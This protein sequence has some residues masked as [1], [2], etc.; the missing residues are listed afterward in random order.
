VV[1]TGDD[2]G[3]EPAGRAC[4]RRST[5]GCWAHGWSTRWAGKSCALA[6]FAGQRVHAVAG[7]GNPQRFF[8]ALRTAGLHPIEHPFPD[9]HRYRPAE[10]QFGEPLP[11]IMTEKDAVKCL[12]FALARCWYLPV[13]A[14]F[15]PADEAP[16]WGEY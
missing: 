14:Q 7:I 6:S 12:S 16:C 2:P 13:S 15:A 4:N 10:L 8:A 1:W 11:V 9:H 3:A 5:C